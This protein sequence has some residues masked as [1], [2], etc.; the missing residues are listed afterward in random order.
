MSTLTSI[1]S[2]RNSDAE[3]GRVSKVENFLKRHNRDWKPEWWFPISI[4][5]VSNDQDDCSWV[6]SH[7]STHLK[8]KAGELIRIGGSLAPA[9][10]VINAL[11]GLQLR[12][13]EDLN[14]ISE[15]LAPVFKT[16]IAWDNGFQITTAETAQAVP[17]VAPE[18]PNEGSAD[19]NTNPVDSLV[20]QLAGMET[21]DIMA[22]FTAVNAARGGL[23]RGA[24]PEELTTFLHSVTG[25]AALTV[26]WPA[27]IAA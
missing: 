12:T 7:S 11:K 14:K 24:Q 9:E 1:Q 5:V 20:T 3:Q 10:E 22:V 21:A 6:R 19:V 13:E 17:Q 4:I 15:V 25:N 23:L 18:T 8:T 26:D 16:P 2:L 27:G